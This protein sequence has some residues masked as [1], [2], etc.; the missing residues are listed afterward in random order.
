MMRRFLTYI[1]KVFH[2]DGLLGYVEDSRTQPQIPP[3]TIWLFVFFMYVAQK[4]SLNSLERELRFPKRLESLVGERK[5]SADRIGDV[6]AMMN[7][8]KLRDFLS[9]INHRL[10]RNK[11]LNTSWPMV[12]VAFDGHEFFSQ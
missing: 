7:T 4:G 8:E 9:E 1:Q 12:F 6:F 5:P 3:V 10:K 11:A 2:F